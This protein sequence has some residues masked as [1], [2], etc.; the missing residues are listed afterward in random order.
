MQHESSTSIHVPVWDGSMETAE[1][2]NELLRQIAVSG[3]AEFVTVHGADELDVE[4]EYLKAS[5]LNAD[6]KIDPDCV[7]R[8]V[9][10]CRSE[11]ARLSIR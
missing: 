2:L 6:E 11:T 8:I 9:S 7:A 5:F 3:R 10:H 4:P 1:A